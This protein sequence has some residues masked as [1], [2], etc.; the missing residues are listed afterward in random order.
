VAPAGLAAIDQAKDDGSWSKLDEVDL[1]T[2]PADLALALDAL[3]PAR[4][5]FDAFPNST[6]RGIPGVDRI[7]EDAGHPREAGR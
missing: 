3:P 4:A 6:R 5:H 1:L 2:V 7:R